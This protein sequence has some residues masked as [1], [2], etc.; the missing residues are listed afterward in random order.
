VARGLL[1]TG[2]NP[3]IL[4]VSLLA[5]V[6]AVAAN[7][8]TSLHP[9]EAYPDN[10]PTLA[11]SGDYSDLFKRVQERLH[12]EGFD[13]GPVNGDWSAKTQ[14]ALAQFQRARDLP[15]SGSLDERT[16]AELG[17]EEKPGGE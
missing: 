14:T 2:M 7:A 15:A 12:A 8:F 5:P 16:R 11:S 3:R 17:I 4:L 13:A 10:V 6:A 1:D 9:E